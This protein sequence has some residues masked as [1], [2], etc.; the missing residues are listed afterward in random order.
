MLWISPTLLLVLPHSIRITIVTGW[1]KWAGGNS[2][3]LS[4]VKNCLA[5]VAEMLH[6]MTNIPSIYKEVCDELFLKNIDYPLWNFSENSSFLEQCVFFLR[7]FAHTLWIPKIFANC[8]SIT[9]SLVLNVKCRL[10]CFLQVLSTSGDGLKDKIGKI[11]GR[12]AHSESI[13]KKLSLGKPSKADICCLK[14]ARKS[15][16]MR[17]RNKSAYVWDLGYRWDP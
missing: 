10:L 13:P 6:C 5:S 17:F 1:V 4:T 12:V 16:Q 8:D 2:P 9:I 7:Q 15:R 14:K 3:S 11:V